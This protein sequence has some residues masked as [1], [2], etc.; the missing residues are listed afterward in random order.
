MGESIIGKMQD[1]T[2]WFAVNALHLSNVPAILENRTITV[3]GTVWEVAEA[4]SGTRYLLSSLVLGLIFASLVYRSW[5]RRLAFVA[6][7]I[8]VPILANG[9]RA[10]GIILLGYI[11]NNKLAAG[12]D[13]IIY[14]FVFFT[15]LQFFLF[16]LGLRWRETPGQTSGEEIFQSRS[17]LNLEA[18]SGSAKPALVAAICALMLVGWL[19]LRAYYVWHHPKTD[20]GTY[21][22]IG[23][24]AP[25]RLLPAYNPNWVPNLNPDSSQSQSYVSPAGRVDTYLAHYSGARGPELVSGYNLVKDPSVWFG[26]SEGLEDATIAG[27]RVVVQQRLLKSLR[28]SRTVWICYWV[29]GEFTGNPERVKFLQAKRRLLGMP[30]NSAILAISVEASE[31]SPKGQALLR[32]FMAAASPRTTPRQPRN[33]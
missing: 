18:N 6:A 9:V 2:A 33:Q 1:F 29:A 10:Y 23:V 26:G 15:I 14:G 19:P 17:V 27:Y 4:C 32:A 16:A 20:T 25:W 12:V 28:D 31:A 21:L 5:T 13:H 30:A 24:D 11:S 7:S 22:S 3:P 8:V